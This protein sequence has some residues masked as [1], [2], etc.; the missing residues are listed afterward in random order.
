MTP[1]QAQRQRER[2]AANSRV[3]AKKAAATRTVH[4]HAKRVGSSST[5]GIWEAMRRR[6]SPVAKGRERAIYFDRGIRVCERWSEFASFLADM[7]QRPSTNHSI[8]RID[9]DGN[10]EPQNCRWATWREQ[11]LNK[12]TTKY[13]TLAGEQLRID[14]WATRLG[15]SLG[16]LRSRVARR[17][18][19]TD[20]LRGSRPRNSATGERNGGATHPERVPRGDSH[21]MARLDADSVREIRRRYAE[22][23]TTMTLLASEFGVTKGTVGFIVRGETWR[24]V[25]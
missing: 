3:G 11:S 1:E 6:C 18:S 10:Y 20:L 24:H 21:G 23:G 25:C 15:V 5:Y 2:A 4:G 13:L 16:A 22:T 19:E 8:D 17:W 12:R 9:N 7:G 14:E